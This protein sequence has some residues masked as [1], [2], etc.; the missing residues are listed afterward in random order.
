MPSFLQSH[1]ERLFLDDKCQLK[2]RKDPFDLFFFFK[3]T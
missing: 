1:F 3:A 2:R